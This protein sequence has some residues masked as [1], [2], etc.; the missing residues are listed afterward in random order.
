MYGNEIPIYPTFYLLEG[1]YIAI[2]MVLTVGIK[3]TV[4]A[5][6]M[7]KEKKEK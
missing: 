6:L 2:A 3:A 4:V 5:M 7:G 1:D